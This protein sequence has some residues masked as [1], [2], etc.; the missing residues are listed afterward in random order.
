M[1]GPNVWR[2]CTEVAR[3]GLEAVGSGGVLLAAKVQ[4]HSSVVRPE[5]N[6]LRLAGLYLSPIVD[7]TIFPQAGGLVPE[8]YGWSTNNSP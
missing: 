7:R 8:E 1:R 5:L 2:S 4:G 6:R 3:L